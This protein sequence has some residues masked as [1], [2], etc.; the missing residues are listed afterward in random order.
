[1]LEG[2]PKDWAP[3]IHVPAAGLLFR[4]PLPQWW[5]EGEPD[6]SLNGRRPRFSGGRVL[7]G[8]SSVNAMVWVRGDPG[9]FDQWAAQ[10][11]AGWDY[12]SVL[13]YF[14][15]AERFS[16]GADSFRG[17][18]GPVR[19]TKQRVRHPLTD[20]FIAAAQEAGVPWNADYNGERQLGVGYG[21][22]NQRRGFRHSTARAYLGPARWRRNLTVLTNASVRKIL[23]DGRCAVGVE[24]RR[25]GETTHAFAAKEVILSA[26]ALGS[27]ALLML[28]GVGPAEHLTELGIPVVT[29]LPP[30]GQ[31]LAEHVTVIPQWD[32]NIRTLN[33]DSH[34][35][36]LFRHGLNF[37][38][39]GRGPVTS[40]ACHSAIFLRNAPDGPSQI[41]GQFCPFSTTVRRAEG[42]GS[43]SGSQGL[44]LT[45]ENR[46]SVFLTLLHPKSRGQLSLRSAGPGEHPVI[47]TN[48]LSDPEEVK[49]MIWGLRSLDSIFSQ[50]ALSPYVVQR[51][52]PAAAA[53]S[54]SDWE[55]FIRQT[56]I[57]GIHTV[58]TC[59]MGAPGDP[60]AVV[61]PQLQVRGVER[62]RVVDASVMPGVTS[63]NTN[64]PT[65][66]I[67]E[68]ASDLIL[69]AS[70]AAPSTPA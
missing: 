25:G 33:R 26:G 10:G 65:I 15:R 64:A 7:G 17:G 3:Q 43:K 14:K 56:A 62:L 16:D 51:G 40:A 68:K 38:L 58:G 32:V 59:M 49:T 8:S 23:F 67:G 69:A 48:L 19:V 27:P 6:V 54:D 2:G 60:R 30:V 22:V 35:A 5:V 29:D 61:D 9:D 4:R 46:V 42:P 36:A 66:M 70:N 39:R 57:A 20:A 55:D 47:R 34:A 50:P 1:L 45:A 28:S 31:N 41:Y 21:Q 18:A 63:G 44:R 37:A 53:L 13:P 52:Q 12:Q 11:C 24:Y